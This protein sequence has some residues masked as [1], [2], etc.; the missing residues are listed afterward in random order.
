MAGLPA[1][2]LI[3]SNCLSSK[4]QGSVQVPVDGYAASYKVPLL[5]DREDES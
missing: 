5:Y 2:Y 4:P 3:D 1:D